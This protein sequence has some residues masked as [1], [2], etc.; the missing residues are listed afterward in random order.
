MKL[1]NTSLF[2]TLFRLSFFSF[3]YKLCLVY[4]QFSLFCVCGDSY[5]VSL[6]SLLHI[7]NRFFIHTTRP[8]TISFLITSAPFSDC[9]ATFISLI[10][11]TISSSTSFKIHSNRHSLFCFSFFRL[12]PCYV[13]N[14]FVY[15][16]IPNILPNLSTP[17]CASSLA[18]SFLQLSFLF[19]PYLTPNTQ[20]HISVLISRWL[21]KTSL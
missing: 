17:H 8:T 1:S 7:S 13:E 20:I 10:F 19:S 16:F 2:F 4:G 6:T 15:T 3:T 14:S 5:L 11:L 18:S 21:Y 12:C 9:P